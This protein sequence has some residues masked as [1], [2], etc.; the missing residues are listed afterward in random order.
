MLSNAFNLL[1]SNYESDQCLDLVKTNK[2]HIIPL[3]LRDVEPNVIKR[4]TVIDYIV[5]SH[6]RLNWRLFE[7]AKSKSSDAPDAAYQNV[8]VENGATSEREGVQRRKLERNEERVWKSIR[9]QMPPLPAESIDH[10]YHSVDDNVN[11]S[12]DNEGVY[13]NRITT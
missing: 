5:Q 1:R 2:K 11:K 8:T 12:S 9:L 13:V 4:S 10:T 7:P 3:F 6:S